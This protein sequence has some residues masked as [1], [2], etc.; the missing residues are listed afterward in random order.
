M[1]G[2]DTVLI[3]EDDPDIADVVALNLRDLGLGTER[4]VDGR[5]G[6]QKAKE[7]GYA[8]VILDL[9]LPGLDGLSVCAR[10][11]EKDPRMPILMLTARSEEIDRVLGLEIGAD[12]YVTKPFSV[13]ELMARVKALLRRAQAEREGAAPGRRAARRRAPPGRRAAA[14]PDR[15]AGPRLRQAAGDPGRARGGAH[16]QGVRPAGPAGRAARGAPTAAPSCS[17]WSGATST[18]GT[19]TR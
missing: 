8:L 15:R 10:L 3:I 7:G 14:H 6:L 19:S 18:R 16:R 5:T 1:A 2:S 17:T 11:R 4:A 9:M 12:D 13:R